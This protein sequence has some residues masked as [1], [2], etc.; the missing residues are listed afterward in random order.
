MRFAGSEMT[1][2]DYPSKDGWA[3]SLFMCGCDFSCKG[4]H[5]PSLQN[6]EYRGGVEL[7][8]EEFYNHCKQETLKYR[9]NNIVL[10]G[11]D[12]LASCNR[13]FTAQFLEQ[14]GGCFN[15]CIY[16]GY[17]IDTVKNLNLNGF[18]F[19]KTG[20]YIKELHQSDTTKGQRTKLVLGSSNQELYNNN[21]VKLTKEGVYYFE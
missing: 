18:K 12:P 13:W 6:P 17:D 8:I 15:I 20:E 16:T 1:F 5:N 21:Y 2:T 11:G 19:I 7:S 10:L 3:V 4:C 14:Y 9:T